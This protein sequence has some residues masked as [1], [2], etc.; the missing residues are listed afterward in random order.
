MTYI[1]LALAVVAE[2]IG[3]SFLKATDEFTKL[4]PTIVVVVC[5]IIAMW[6]LTLVLREMAVGIVYAIW[7]GMGIVLVTAVA[8]IYYKE[9]PDLAAIIGMVLIISGVV[10]MHL[11]SGSIKH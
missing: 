3:T 11:F 4:T 2:V 1:Y 9:I 8:A 6:L 5:Y 10:V 7:S